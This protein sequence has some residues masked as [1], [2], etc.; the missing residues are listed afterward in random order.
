M[1]HRRISWQDPSYVGEARSNSVVN[2]EPFILMATTE[3]YEHEP[4][5]TND[6]IKALTQEIIKTIRDI[7]VSL[8]FTC[9]PNFD[10]MDKKNPLKPNVHILKP[11]FKKWTSSSACFSNLLQRFMRSSHHMISTENLVA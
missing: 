6:E 11:T 4:Y 10:S 3:N 8:L 7:I 1:A 9:Q 2:K 5:V